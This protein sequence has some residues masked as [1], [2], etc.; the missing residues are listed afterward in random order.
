[1]DHASGRHLISSGP[2]GEKFFG[3]RII[4]SRAYSLVALLAFVL[5]GLPGHAW[6]EPADLS[7]SW[8]G[9][10][11]VSFSPGSRERARCRAHYAPH[12]GS[13]YAV[14]AT[15]AT[16]S[17]SVSQVATLRRVGS[18]TYAGGFYNNEYGVTGTIQVVVRGNSQSVTLTSDSGTASLTLTR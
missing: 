8:R 2:D 18:N 7:G 1:M 6:S 3:K 4:V 10:G 15:C 14:S 12:S 16:E 17:G 5:L 9:G 13:G 11:W